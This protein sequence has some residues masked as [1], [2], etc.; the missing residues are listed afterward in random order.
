MARGYFRLLAVKDEYEVARLYSDGEFT[1]AVQRQFSGD[2]KVRY[3]LAHP[4]LA[5]PDP[6]TGRIRKQTYG[7]WMGKLFRVLARLKRV[8]GTWLDP[9]GYTRERAMERRLITDYEATVGGLLATL[10]SANYDVT[11]EIAALP[12]QMRGYGPVKAANVARAKEREAGLLAD[13][14]SKTAHA[15]RATP[16]KVSDSGAT[17]ASSHDLSE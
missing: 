1:R 10:N 12:A 17:L 6:V 5:R 9:F 13:F 14:Q 8:R 7:A 15:V 11:A 2:Y 3:H 16:L 4:L